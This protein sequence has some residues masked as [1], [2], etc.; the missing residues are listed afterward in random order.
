MIV[1][2]V[3]ERAVSPF[4]LLVFLVAN[5]RLREPPGRGPESLRGADPGRRCVPSVASKGDLVCAN[6]RLGNRAGQQWPRKPRPKRPYERP[7]NGQRKPSPEKP[8]KQRGRI[9]PARGRLKNLPPKRRRG[10]QSAG[11]SGKSLSQPLSNLCI[12]E[13]RNSLRRSMRCSQSRLTMVAASARP[14]NRS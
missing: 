11:R 12:A 8:R 14:F 3:S 4:A 5:P 1:N 7:P 10:S 2:I 9:N 13:S 6:L